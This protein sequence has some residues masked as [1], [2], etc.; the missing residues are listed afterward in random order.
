MEWRDGVLVDVKHRPIAAYGDAPQAGY[1]YTAFCQ[2]VCGWRSSEELREWY[3]EIWSYPNTT[4]LLDIL[5]P[6]VPTQLLWMN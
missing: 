5:F 6:K 4:V 1:P 3:P 2:L